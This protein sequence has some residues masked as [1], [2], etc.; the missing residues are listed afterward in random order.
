M[1]RLVSTLFASAYTRMT[2]PARP[3]LP[4]LA[5]LTA[6]VAIAEGGCSGAQPAHD[7]DANSRP[8]AEPW[9]LLCPPVIGGAELAVEAVEGGVGVVLTAAPAMAED[10]YQRAR[11]LADSLAATGGVTPAASPSSRSGMGDGG[12]TLPRARVSVSAVNGGARLVLEAVDR[13]EAALLGDRVS[14]LLH[15]M[16]SGGCPPLPTRPQADR[17]AAPPVD[18]PSG[19]H[20]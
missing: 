17:P 5:I 20:H 14:T 13:S 12:A 15:R 6:A 10:V 19:H 4:V 3:R 11:Q 18:R 2:G 16:L 8:V 9:A 1:R 7:A